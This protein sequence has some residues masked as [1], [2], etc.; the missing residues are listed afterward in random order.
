MTQTKI[1]EILMLLFTHDFQPSSIVEDYGFRR[2]V[3]ILN[4]SYQLP[5]R[6]TITNSFLP[7]QFKKISNRQKK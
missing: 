1:D 5:A 6:K 7:A 3:N 2:F 4:P